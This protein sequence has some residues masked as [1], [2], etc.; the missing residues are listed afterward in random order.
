MFGNCTADTSGTPINAPVGSWYYIDGVDVV[1]NRPVEGAVVAI[2]DS[3]TDGF[4]S[5]IDA[6]R[7]WPKAPPGVRRRDRFCQGARG[8]RRPD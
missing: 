1:P 5:T 2:G 3:I 4:R 8:S 6:N 7:R